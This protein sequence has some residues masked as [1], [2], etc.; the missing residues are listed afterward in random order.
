MLPHPE[1]WIVVRLLSWH[2]PSIPPPFSNPLFF[3]FVL[4]L[5]LERED[6]GTRSPK[7][8][9]GGGT[10]NPSTSP[11]HMTDFTSALL[12]CHCIVDIQK[13]HRQC[14]V[15]RWIRERRKKKKK[16]NP[17]C[18]AML[19]GCRYESA[20]SVGGWRGEWEHILT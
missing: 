1:G 5:P 20:A 10:E 9:E 12:L 7:Q 4:S 18:N 15:F 19:P 17:G 11:I 13:Q 3:H 8:R 2:S 14:V 6:E 16:K